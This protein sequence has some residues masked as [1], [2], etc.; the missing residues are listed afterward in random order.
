MA[1]D[2]LPSIATPVQGIASR[3]Q[4]W[5]RSKRK[6]Q[7]YGRKQIKKGFRRF[8]GVHYLRG[9]NLAQVP[10]AMSRIEVILRF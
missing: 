6:R 4:V 1:Q 10:L 9:K 3:A 7:S 5:L 2:S 8:P